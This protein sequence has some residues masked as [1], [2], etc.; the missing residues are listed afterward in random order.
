MGKFY[1]M[2]QIFIR[3]TENGTGSLGQKIFVRIERVDMVDED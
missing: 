2:W 1:L 3:R